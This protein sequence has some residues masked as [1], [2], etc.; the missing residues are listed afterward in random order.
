MS[1]IFSRSCSFLCSRWRSVLLTLAV[2]IAVPLI[3][4]TVID[5]ARARREL[6]A[7]VKAM[8]AAHPQWRIDDIEAARRT[9]PEAENSA[10]VILKTNE[11]LPK[12]WSWPSAND[13][14]D[15]R[16]PPTVLLSPERA[17]ALKQELDARREALTIA[18]TLNRIPTGR[19]PIKFEPNFFST[20]I[21]D[22]AKSRT[23]YALLEL[24]LRHHLQEANFE[25]ADETLVA[26]WNAGQALGDEPLLISQLI[27]NAM[28]AGTLNGLERTLACGLLPADALKAWRERLQKEIDHETFLIGYRGEIA[29]QYQMLTNI[30]DGTVSF[31]SLSG[32][33]EA[34][35]SL[36]N[37]FWTF[38][39]RNWIIQ[40]QAWF[41][42]RSLDILATEKMSPWQ[43]HQRL[44]E[45]EL[46]FRKEWSEDS[47]LMFAKMLMPAIFKVA[48]S[49]TRLEGRLLC[50]QA[51]LAAEEFRLA[52]TRWPKSLAELVEAK[53]LPD[54]P[55]DPF[56]GEPLRF[57]VAKDGIV[58]YSIGPTGRD[59][60][61]TWDMPEE[62]ADGLA[63]SGRVEFRLWNESS[64][65]RKA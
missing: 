11:K 54:V 35:N 50:A 28:V 18:R 33:H 42:R 34:A 32:G 10:F 29:G 41:M 37:R 25:A 9:I 39:V 7:A 14:D 5:Y 38:C 51:G 1:N 6:A 46:E 58:I 26:M 43:R 4:F 48:E 22:Q 8:D 59:R 16:T 55:K 64:R 56:D 12:D 49:E 2:L 13:F 30:L 62:E 31:D 15:E 36:S 40:S 60:G 24:E 65:R 20:V 27:R 47:N 21:A 52:N 57:R 45:L 44:R 61:E 3:K 23:V 63:I 53:L 19:F 17:A